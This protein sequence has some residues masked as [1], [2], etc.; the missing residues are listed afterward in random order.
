MPRRFGGRRESE[1]F[2]LLGLILVCLATL[3]QATIDWLQSMSEGAY[4]P[5]WQQILIV[6]MLLL[7]LMSVLF[8]LIS[9]KS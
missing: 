7:A 8:S 4:K 9:S 3:I 2:A 6:G 5:M 1:I